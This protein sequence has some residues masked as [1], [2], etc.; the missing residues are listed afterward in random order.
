MKPLRSLADRKWIALLPC[1]VCGSHESD[2][3][4]TKDGTQG[5]GQKSSDYSCIP[6]C[7]ACHEE[8]HRYGRESEWAASVGIDMRALVARLNAAWSGMGRRAT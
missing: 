7:R 2:P 1:S 6:L 3:A 5:M 4:H 8:Y